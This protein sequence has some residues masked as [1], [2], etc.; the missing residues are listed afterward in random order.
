VAIANREGLPSLGDTSNRQG[1]FDGSHAP[2][3]MQD[4]FVAN[5]LAEVSF[6]IELTGPKVEG[7]PPAAP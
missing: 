7:Q 4:Y 2:T 6:T 3:Y 5:T 1:F